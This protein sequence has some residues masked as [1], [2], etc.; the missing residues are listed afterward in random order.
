MCPMLRALCE[1]RDSTAP[2]LTPLS[3][4]LSE[5]TASRM[6]SSR[7]VEGSLPACNVLSSERSFLHC[8]PLR[9][10]NSLRRRGQSHPARDPS[11]ALALAARP[12]T[13]L[14][15]TEE[16]GAEKLRAKQNVPDSFESW[17]AMSI[18]PPPSAAQ[19]GD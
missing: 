17:D 1:K 13:P 10:E 11:T 16:L 8:S 12:P 4:I 14:R 18:S 2:S 6:R 19:S 15:M 9:G 5:A 3:V 7:A